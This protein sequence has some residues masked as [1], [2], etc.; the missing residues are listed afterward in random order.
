MHAQKYSPEVPVYELFLCMH[1][2]KYKLRGDVYVILKHRGVLPVIM[3]TSR[4]GRG[5]TLL[6]Y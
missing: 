5:N 4:R 3:K 1:D 2:M 6:S